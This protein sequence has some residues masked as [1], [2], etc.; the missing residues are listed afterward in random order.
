M[1]VAKRDP[2]EDGAHEPSYAYDAAGR[3]RLARTVSMLQVVGSLL[4]IPVGLASA[5]SVYRANF[6][7]ETTCQSLRADILTMIDKRVDPSTRRILARRDVE[8]FEQT[9]GLI[10]PD[11][12]A[13]FKR[14]LAVEKPATAPVAA[15]VARTVEEPKKDVVKKDVARRDEPKPQTIAKMPDSAWPGERAKHEA[16]FSDTQWLDAVRQA[17]VTHETKRAVAEPENPPVA[18][19]APAAPPVLQPAM[20]ETALPVQTAPAAAPV[21]VPAPALPPAA[22]VAVPAASVAAPA[23]PPVERQQA[24]ADHPVPPEAIPDPAQVAAAEANDHRSRVRRWISK[25]PLMGN[26]IDNGLQ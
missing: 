14:L 5:Y 3:P 2:F 22:T 24:D 6:S 9:C 18:V 17:L 15:P 26:V 16:R 23:T 4:A 21:A 1:L 11:A 8:H 12:T 13:A 20:R 7:V 10:D 19:A 25:I